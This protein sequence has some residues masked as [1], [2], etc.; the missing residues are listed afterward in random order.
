MAK[1]KVYR[2][3]EMGVTSLGWDSEGKVCYVGN[4]NNEIWSIELDRQKS[5]LGMFLLLSVTVYQDPP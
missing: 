3:Y 1:K 4:N 5:D 2:K